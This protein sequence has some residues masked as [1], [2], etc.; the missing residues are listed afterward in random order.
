MSVKIT[1]EFP[2]AAEALA[3]LQTLTTTYVPETPRPT[4]GRKAAADAATT[5]AG[6]P[7]VTEAPTAAA[8]DSSA[9][10]TAGAVAAQPATAPVTAPAAS[11]SKEP[12]VKDPTLDD[13]RNALVKAQTRLGSKDKPKAVLDKYS[14]TGTTGGLDK[15]D[16]GKVIA[17][18]E[19]LK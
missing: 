6:T 18:C 3:A 11:A 4:R 1:L 16:Y 12:V 14:K 13:V 19:T 7:T 5:S 15:A 2:G 10:T 8:S 17:A 9:P